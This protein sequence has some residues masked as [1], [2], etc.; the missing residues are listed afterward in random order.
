MPTSFYSPSKGCNDRDLGQVDQI[1]ILLIAVSLMALTTLLACG[2]DWLPE[3][4]PPTATVE[5]RPLEELSPE[6][7]GEALYQANCQACHGASKV[8]DGRQGHLL[9]MTLGTPGTIRTHSSRTG[10]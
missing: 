5:G 3:E 8:K 9:I 4:V 6:R 10:S 2:Q 7:R 1:P